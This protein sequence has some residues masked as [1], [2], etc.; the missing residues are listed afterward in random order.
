MVE[1]EHFTRV[2]ADYEGTGDAWDAT[3]TAAVGAYTSGIT[4]SNPTVQAI[5]LWLGDSPLSPG[6]SLTATELYQELLHVYATCGLRL[7][8][9]NPVSLGNLLGKQRTALRS[10]GYT[11]KL[12]SRGTLHTFTPDT[13]TLNA[14]TH[15]SSGLKSKQSRH[16]ASMGMSNMDSQGA[17]RTG[18]PATSD[19]PPPDN[20]DDGINDISNFGVN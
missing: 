5:R 1:F 20:Q 6:K 8:I 13:A 10:L 17:F 19:T 15:E 3:W 9:S 7:S 4:E 16:I 14:C 18:K 2:C 12:S 11:S